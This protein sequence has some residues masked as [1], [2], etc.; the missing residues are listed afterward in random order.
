MSLGW[1]MTELWPSLELGKESY[2]LTSKLTI[3]CEDSKFLEVSYFLLYRN[4]N[5]ELFEL[6]LVSLCNYGLGCNCLK[7]YF[8]YSR[9]IPLIFSSIC[10][11][12]R[13]TDYD[14]TNPRVEDFVVKTFFCFLIS[15]YFLFFYWVTLLSWIGWKS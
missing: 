9:L 14:S 2:R 1:E 4:Y 7:T 10:F 3:W 12:I 13:L 15:V 6:E 5:L 8:P 11:I